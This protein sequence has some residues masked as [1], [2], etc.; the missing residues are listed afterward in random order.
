LSFGN[1]LVG[2]RAA[3]GVR[4]LESPLFRKLSVVEIA[5]RAGFSDASHFARVVRNRT[6]RTPTQLRSVPGVA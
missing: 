1:L 5:H 4:M 3:V 6:G 2:A